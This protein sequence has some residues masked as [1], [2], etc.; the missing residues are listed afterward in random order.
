[1]IL[2]NYKKYNKLSDKWSQLVHFAGEQVGFLTCTA[3]SHMT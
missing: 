1:M 2:T 3:A